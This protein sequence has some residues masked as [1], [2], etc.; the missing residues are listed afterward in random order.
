MLVFWGGLNFEMGA[1]GS[2]IIMGYIM[3]IMDYK[4]GGPE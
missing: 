3:G 2:W 1:L 4:W